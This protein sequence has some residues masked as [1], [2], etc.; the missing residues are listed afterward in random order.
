VENSTTRPSSSSGYGKYVL[1]IALTAIILVGVFAFVYFDVQT[2]YNALVKTQERMEAKI[3]S[4][5]AQIGRLQALLQQLTRSNTSGPF[6]LTPTQIYNMSK[7]SVVL[8]ANRRYGIGGLKTVAE[9]SGFIYDK[10]GYIITNNHVVE[11]ADKIRVT[12][13]D[14]TV[15]EATLVGADVYSDLAVIKVDLPPEKASSLLRPLTLG[16]SSSLVVGEPVYAIGNPFGLSGSMTQGIVSQLGRSIQAKGGYSIVDVIQ[17]DAAIN[18]GNSGGPLLN[19][20]GE[21][22]GITTAI[23][24]TTGTFSGVGFA[25]PSNLIK[26]VV[27]ALIETG[28]YD[29]PWVGVQG[30]NMMPEIAEAMKTNYTH[31][32]LVTAVFPDSPAERAGLRGGNKTIIVEDKEIPIGGD[33]I[34][35]V[36]GHPILNVD[37][38]L[39]YLERYKSPGEVIHLLIV[40]NN[41]PQEVPL[42]LGKRP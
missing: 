15:A 6:A 34:V 35:G 26:R 31:G 21:V 20:K 10:R 27:P 5:E 32:F 18:P 3:E 8:I 29:H 2:K 11:G 4:A 22:V 9:G 37:E 16:N 24:T 14:G 12:F 33:I 23:V 25:I 17:I 41:T 42:T 1:T 7:Q 39:T 28:H 36:D 13:P 30:V 40:R 38:L 19:G